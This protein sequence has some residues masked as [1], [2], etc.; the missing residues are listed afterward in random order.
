MKAILILLL[1]LVVLA[2]VWY[3]AYGREW[4]KG[5]PWTEGFFAAIEPLEIALYK[6]SETILFARL[7]ILTGLVL[8]ALTM[9]GG[10]D[11][12]MITPFVP[13]QHQGLVCLA[14]NLLPL[15]ISLVGM[16]DERLRNE[17]TKPL[18][19]VAIGESSPLPPKVEI[20]IAEAEISKQ[21]A[22]AV[23]KGEGKKNDAKAEADA[24]RLD[25]SDA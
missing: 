25:Q 21:L 9:L 7:K 3:A 1:V 15:A 18:E 4:L 13:E 17:T 22:V 19:L 10:I 16:L 14:V 8:S 24:D 2:V 11:L 23:V 6:K 20:A 12:T 5:K